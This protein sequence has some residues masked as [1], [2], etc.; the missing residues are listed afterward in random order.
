MNKNILLLII[1]IVIYSGIQAQEDISQAHWQTD[2]I[3]IDG[4]N[5]DWNTPLN[6][7]DDGTGLLFGISNDKKNIYLCFAGKDE[8]KKGANVV[9]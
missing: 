7:F 3:V 8:M 2:K 9:R 4:N 5:K 1:S 6:L